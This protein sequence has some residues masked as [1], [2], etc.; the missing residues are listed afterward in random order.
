MRILLLTPPMIQV[1]T[2][3]PATPLLCGYL[4]RLGHEA[5]QADASLEL[6]LRLFSRPTL[7]QIATILR[8][9]PT[10]SP[11]RRSPSVAAFLAQ[12]PAYLACV[13]PAVRF[14]QG[15]DPALGWR[16]ATRNFLPEGPRFQAIADMP[17]ADDD[18]PLD[19]IFGHLGTADRAAYLASLFLDDLADM[20]RDGIDPHFEFARYG[21]KLASSATTF[22]P[23]AT[24][25]QRPPTQIDRLLADIAND[26][27]DQHRPELV[28]LTLP[29]P[30]TVYGACRIAAEVR[31][32]RP[33]VP[34]VFGG[35]Y[36]NTELRQLSDPQVFD[37]CDYI[38]LDDGFMPLRCL[39]EH[40][41]GRRKRRHLA[42]TFLRAKGKVQ[43]VNGAPEEDLPHGESGPPT[44]AGLALDRYLPLL[45]MP[46]PMHRLWSGSRWNKLQLAH[47]CHWRRCRF[48]DTTLDYIRRHDPA[49]AEQVVDWI[50]SVQAETGQTGFHFVDE[51]APPSLL[52]HMSQRL[53]ER[54]T[55]ITW[56]TNIRFERAFTP[57]LCRL[58]AQAGCVAVT[59]GLETPVDRLL[60]LMDKGTTV[61]RAA[62]AMAAFADAGILVHAYLMYG[63]PTQTEAE[64][65]DGLEQVRRL[66]ADGCLHSAYWHRF[67]LTVHSP[68][69]QATDELGIRLPPRPQPTFASNELPYED[70]AGVDFT[71]LGRALRHATYNYM[72]GL[73]LDRD[74]HDWFAPP[75]P[76]R[77]PRKNM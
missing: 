75:S 74:V 37:W 29:F 25:L 54:H 13:D 42:R 34:V 18:D 49:S 36:V 35:G 44:Y 68:L 9:R 15:R 5:T 10:A 62:Q 71:R 19:A 70:L 32:R 7:A 28:L 30:G 6:S 8:R 59:G 16:I 56:W 66:F 73:G 57:E 61:A 39:I 51:A 60:A 72:L 58:L 20:L 77:K 12:L 69:A 46:N 26:W 48:C 31:R 41:D 76:R 65:V 53:L 52:R 11:Q 67:A 4:R 45:E 14:L 55:S 47:G 17:H 2:P 27:L 38:T 24:A 3:Y 23:L 33:R 21:E 50:E 1:N 64:V 63:F 22:A 43:Y 40:L